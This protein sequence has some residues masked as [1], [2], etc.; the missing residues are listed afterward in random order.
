MR[1]RWPE[2]TL[3]DHVD[4]LTG[5]PFK[6][7]DF[8]RDPQDVPLVKGSVVAP[9]HLVWKGCERLNHTL[10]RD[11]D[12]YRLHEGDVILALDRPWIEAGLKFAW[13]KKTDPTALLVQRVARLRGGP[14]LDTTFLRYLIASRAFSDYVAPITTGVNVPHLSPSQVAAFRFA[15]PPVKTQRKI[16]SVL[17]VY[18]EL[19]ENNSRRI[20]LLEEMAQRI[21]REWFVDYRYRGHDDESGLDGERQQLPASWRERH[22]R[23]LGTIT[24]GQ[25]PPSSSYN[26]TGDGLP[27]HQGVGTFG[28]HFPVL[29]KYSRRGDRLAEPGDVLLSVRAPVGRINIADRKMILGRGLCSI[30]GNDAPTLFLLYALKHVFQE[31][32]SMGGGSIFNAVTKKDVE[33]IS[34]LWPGRELVQAFAGRAGD[35]NALI[36]NLTKAN[37]VLRAS[38]DLLLPQLISGKLETA[39]LDISVAEAAA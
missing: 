23:E 7:K 36:A 1:A 21:Y 3:G 25:S 19:I 39:N 35:T 14:T 9:G 30:R 26:T 10:A 12:K 31:E 11:F 37:S 22:L 8:T 32:D 13:I 15:L 29:T 27:F 16:A 34:I 28:E 5:F 24:M 2:V 17:S 4:M 38:R 20:E 18:D 6:S 33:E